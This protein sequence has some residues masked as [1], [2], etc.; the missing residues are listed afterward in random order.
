MP[1][2]DRYLTPHGRELFRLNAKAFAKKGCLVDYIITSPLVRCVQTADI[3]AE[4]IRFSG[5]LVAL[6]EVAPGF[7][8]ARLYQVIGSARGAQHIAL[9]GHEPDLGNIITSLLKSSASFSLK[10][11]MIVS[12]DV[13]FNQ[14]EMPARLNWI[15]H[16]G[17]KRPL[18][19]TS[20]R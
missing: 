13:I 10:K 8:A 17:K 15:L 7:N 12:L 6:R 2:E 14:H 19:K 16:K 9:V 5:E 4:A 1:D 20:A 3:L 11:G 18:E